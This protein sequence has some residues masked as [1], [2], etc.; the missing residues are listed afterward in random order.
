M[1]LIKVVKKGFIPESAGAPVVLPVAAGDNDDLNYFQA[2]KPHEKPFE[3]HDGAALRRASSDTARRIN[4]RFLLKLIREHQPISRADLTRRSGLQRSTV[5]VITQQLLTSHWLR[6]GNRGE[7]IRGRRPIF[8]HLNENHIGFFGVNI[9]QYFTHIGLANLNGKFIVRDT[10]P[11]PVEFGGVVDRLSGVVRDWR[12]QFPHMQFAEIGLSVPGPIH[13][14]S[15]EF[16]LGPRRWNAA[17]LKHGLE[18]STR[19]SVSIETAANACAL[20]EM[21]FNPRLRNSRNTVVVAVSETI[22]TGIIVN[23][24]LVRGGTAAAAGFGHVAISESGPLCRCGKRGC[25]ETFASN[26]A[27]IGHY[28]ER[29]HPKDRVTAF[30]EILRL[31]DLSDFKAMAALT[32][33]VEGLG[34]G[35]AILV[36]GFAPDFVSV[37]GDVT[38]CWNR[39]GPL[40]IQAA[41]K[42]VFRNAAV[43]IIAGGLVPPPGLQGVTALFLQD[44]FAS[45]IN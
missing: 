39:L 9:Q 8:L 7:S 23:G 12:N 6:E 35:I 17:H 11:T 41:R 32:K 18:N 4:R 30:D 13:P 38:R 28:N 24:Q 34:A 37:V 33:M 27:A 19:M 45:P 31:A 43:N 2:L 5:S 22:G 10:L 36:S 29:C 1:F 42:R 40:I 21:W 16:M 20:S 44:H 15:H 25:W 26:S 14:S 3:K